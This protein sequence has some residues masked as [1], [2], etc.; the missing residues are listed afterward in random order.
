MFKS[1]EK[2]FISSKSQSVKPDV[3]SDVK[4]LDQIRLLVP[5][6]VSFLDPTD[7]YLKF[8][9]KME[10]AR[11][12]IVPDHKGGCHSLFR[13]VILRDGGNTA[14]L[15]S[16]E[17]YN[18][19][20]CMTRPYTA[21][22]SIS[23]KR[24]LVEGVQQDANNSGESLYYSAPNTLQNANDVATADVTP[25]TA[26]EIEVYLKLKTGLFQNGIV[27]VGLM[28][29]LRL[30]IDTEDPLRCLRQPFIGG[31]LEDPDTR[32]GIVADLGIGGLGNR[33]GSAGA[34]V[35]D[36]LVNITTNDAGANN[37]FAI[38]DILYMDKKN[39]GGEYGDNEIVAGVVKGFYK[40]ANDKLGIK[41]A[42][43]SNTGV[44]FPT[45]AYAQA[46][47][48]D[49]IVY[50]K[51]ADR[52]KVQSV[53]SL[54]ATNNNKDETIQPVS[55]T[56]SNLEMLCSAVQPPSA[57]QE[58][59]LRKSMSAEGVELDYMTAELHRF[60]QVNAEGLSQI[61]IPTLATRGKAVFCQPIPVANY[62]TLSKSSFSGVPD[63]AKNYQFVKGSEL[64]PSRVVHLER[65]S[66]VVGTAG[67]VRN[68]PLHTSEL[69]KSLAN[70][71][72]P[73][74]SLQ[75][76]SDSFAIARAFNKYGQIT[77]LADETLS[78]RVDYGAG[79]SQKVFN[80]FIY[81]LARLT[82]SRGNV[83]VMS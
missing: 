83:S 73:V 44:A 14:T 41:L 55:Y 28:S 76:I 5:S 25:R 50:Y 26:K 29:G 66:Q 48:D 61:Q 19:M 24:E 39:A 58:G 15:E 10:N 32:S 79:A 64:I 22:S 37:H 9:V 75:R 53:L 72:E 4:P 69:Q 80:N 18:A 17:D 54:N 3:V 6:F 16:L 40:G 81:K 23:H 62:R 21:Q 42:L 12:V 27:P 74:F 56:I 43:Q 13:N 11:G 2:Q 33:D 38:N 65:Y 7:T 52:G 30:Q 36:L 35:G 57:Y 45:V 34:N 47:T 78:L 59:M 49:T 67:Q 8:S 82:V 31:S 77:N 71:N 63:N 60:N 1:S 46:G 20:C 70:V 51:V 68:E